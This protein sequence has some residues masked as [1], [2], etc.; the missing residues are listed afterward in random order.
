MGVREKEF[1]M[2]D[3][4]RAEELLACAVKAREGS[5]SPYSNFCVGAA[6][7]CSDGEI[8]TGANVENASYGGAI[9]AERVAITG[10]VS[11]GHREFDAIAIVGAPK[12]REPV[13]ECL[14]CGFCRQVM[15]EFCSGEF[16]IILSS[17]DGVKIYKLGELMPHAFSPESLK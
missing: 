3:I 15:A 13:E 2:T 10:A 16:E 6:V 7:L 5:Y 4:K 14:P 17:R 9:C 11:H 12:G 8:F 1:Y